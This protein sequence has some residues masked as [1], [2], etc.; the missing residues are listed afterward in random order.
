MFADRLNRSTRYEFPVNHSAEVACNAVTSR[1]SSSD[2]GTDPVA[3]PTAMG[4]EYC[5]IVEQ[6]GNAVTSVEPGQF[7]IGSFFAADETCPHCQVGYQTSCQQR[8]FV[9]SAQPPI[10]CTQ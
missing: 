5:G 1:L 8:E 6:V 7:V 10:A 9:S 2:R 3:Q 4:R